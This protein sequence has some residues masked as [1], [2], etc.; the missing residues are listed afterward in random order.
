MVVGLPLPLI[1]IYFIS[2][3][4]PYFISFSFG[5]LVLGVYMFFIK[6]IENHFDLYSEE[7]GKK[8]SFEGLCVE[9]LLIGLIAFTSFL[10]FYYLLDGFV[11]LLKEGYNFK[12]CVDK[13]M[14]K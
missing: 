7:E 9:S 13:I 12:E 14:Y 2:L 8:Y 5:F 11:S 4:S 1:I 6:N 10:P 3:F